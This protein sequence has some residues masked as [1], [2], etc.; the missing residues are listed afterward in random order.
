MIW[1]LGAN[2]GTYSRLAAS[3]APHVVSFDGDHAVVEQQ[4]Q[5]SRATGRS[6]LPLVQN[7]TNPSAALGWSHSERRSLLE[8]GPADVALALA[9]I[10]H[11]SIGSNVPL[12]SVAAFFQRVCRYLIIEFVPREDS[13]VQRMLTLREDVFAAY[14]R[15]DFERAFGAH[16]RCLRSTAIDG[17]VRTLYLMERRSE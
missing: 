1:D 16:F 3:K 12:D 6:I 17:T 14:T 13:Q 8:R 2:T 11:L 7:L 4:F 5:E 10:H 9:L 15:T